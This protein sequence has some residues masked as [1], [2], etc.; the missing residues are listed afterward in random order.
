MAEVST[1]AAQSTVAAPD[2][3]HVVTIDEDRLNDL[4]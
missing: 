1:A 2:N 3:I 4:I